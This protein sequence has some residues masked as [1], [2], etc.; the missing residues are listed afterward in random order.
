MRESVADI[1]S[2]NWK[3]KTVEQVFDFYPTASYPRDKQ[4]DSST[5]NEVIKYIHYGDI[6]TKFNIILDIS[7]SQVPIIPKDLQNG[8]EL[9]KDGDLIIADTSEDYDGVGKCVEVI[10]ANDSPTISGLHTLMLRQKEDDFVDGFKGYYFSSEYIRN[11]LLR[12]VT[13]IKVYSINKT[14]LAKVKL[15]I[16][17]KAE[18]TEI[19][20][21]LSKVDEAIAAVQT[22]IDAAER[23]KKS[24]M[25]NLLTGKM[26]PDGTFRTPEEFYTDPKF[27]KVPLGWEVK[28]VKECFKF[29]NGKGN[30]TKNLKVITYDEYSISVYG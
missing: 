3:T 27:G 7:K 12:I 23:L 9:L 21:I 10:N 20:N 22:S 5:E 13:G 24:L 6:H 17:P 30:A 28:K 1:S 29:K 8:F 15:Y 19:A 26:K 18:Q 11:K 2:L 25:Q 4:C 14:S 16:P